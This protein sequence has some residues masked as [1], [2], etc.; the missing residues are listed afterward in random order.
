M[1]ALFI[2]TAGNQQNSVHHIDHTE[3]PADFSQWVEH[4]RIEGQ[5]RQPL[6]SRGLENRLEGV[7]HETQQR[8]LVKGWNASHQVRATLEVPT[9]SVTLPSLYLTWLVEVFSTD[10]SLEAPRHVQNQSLGTDRV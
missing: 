3:M 9:A 7:G 1:T 5:R 10:V 8:L 6:D 4:R 2:F